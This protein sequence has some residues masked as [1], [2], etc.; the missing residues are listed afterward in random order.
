M[1]TWKAVVLASVVVALMGRCVDVQAKSWPMTVIGNGDQIAV[2]IGLR[3]GDAAGRSEVGLRLGWTD[4]LDGDQEAVKLA[5]YATWDVLKDVDLPFVMPFGLG[6]G[7]I[8][9]TGYLGALV[10]VL[11]NTKG[12]TD[13]DAVAAGLVGVSMG[14]ERIRVSL[15]YQLPVTEKFWEVLTVPEGSRLL[16]GLTYRW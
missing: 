16:L 15:E 2:G 3:P 13:L 10:G 9:A 11:A 1:K 4:G 5:A 14:D 8:K 7:N 6:G 12:E